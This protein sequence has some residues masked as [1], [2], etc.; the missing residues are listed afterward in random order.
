MG[1]L[2]RLIGHNH[3]LP[4]GSSMFPH[5]GWQIFRLLETAVAMGFQ[6]RD[7]PFVNMMCLSLNT[8]AMQ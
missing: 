2:F 7:V 1:Q 8:V 5:E 4:Q 6:V 3:G